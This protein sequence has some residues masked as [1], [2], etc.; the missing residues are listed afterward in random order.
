VPEGVTH[1][2]KDLF[3]DIT[4]YQLILPKTLTTISK[5]AIRY[6]YISEVTFKSMPILTGEDAVIDNTF[7]LIVGLPNTI[8]LVWMIVN[9]D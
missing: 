7:G 1:I 3:D 2:A 6:T 5:F 4:M 8:E 9:L